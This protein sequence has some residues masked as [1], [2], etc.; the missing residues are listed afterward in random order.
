MIGPNVTSSFNQ[1]GND[2]WSATHDGE[3][4]ETKN[5]TRLSNGV[6]AKIAGH[7]GFRYTRCQICLYAP[8]K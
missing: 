4:I 6:Y 8:S 3:K 1:L 7:L 2:V 5:A